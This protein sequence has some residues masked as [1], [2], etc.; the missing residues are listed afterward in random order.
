MTKNNLFIIPARKNSKRLKN[1]NLMKISNKTLLEIK[2][3]ICKKTKIGSIVVTSDDDLILNNSKDLGVKYLRKRPNNLEGDGP[4]TPILYDAVK[5]YENLTGKKTNIIILSQLTSP[6]ILKEN[7]IESFNFFIKN[8]NYNSLISC[9]E[10][11]LNLFW[12]FFEANNNKSFDFPKNIKNQLIKFSANKKNFLPNGGIYMIKRSF[13]KK[14]G[15]VYTHPLKIW[16]MSESQSID[17]D[18]QRD[19]LLARV[20]NKKLKLI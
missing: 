20:I 11:N 13:L 18:Y 7:F 10:N 16:N 14:R 15:K 2:I 1:K 19:L 5:Y 3:N 8:N 6:F 4:T 9:R 17:I 12:S